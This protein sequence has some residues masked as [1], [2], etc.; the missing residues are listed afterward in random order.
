MATFARIFTIWYS[1]YMNQSDENFVVKPLKQ[2]AECL[3]ESRFLRKV[4]KRIVSLLSDQLREPRGWKARYIWWEMDRANASWLDWMEPFLDVKEGD[5]LL[6][7]WYGTGKMIERLLDNYSETKVSGI[8][9]S[10]AMKALTTKNNQWH[11]GS[12]RLVLKSGTSEKMPF[13]DEL[14]DAVY[15]SNVIYFWSDLGMTFQELFRVTKQG[16]RTVLYFIDPPAKANRWAIRHDLD[17]IE[18]TLE[19]VWFWSVE[20]HK[21]DLGKVDRVCFVATR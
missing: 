9:I 20:I 15:T 11:I 3:L 8:D 16:W 18:D 4:R 7:I 17:T 1:F 10:D 6:E 14:F 12:G 5:Q 2:F 21:E 19:S 13:E